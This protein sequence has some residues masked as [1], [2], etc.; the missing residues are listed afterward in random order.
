MSIVLP[1]PNCGPRP[2][3]EFEYGEIPVVPES[4]TAADER[5]LDRAFMRSNPEGPQT[6]RWFHTFGCRRWLTLR[7]DT[8]TDEVLDAAG[9]AADRQ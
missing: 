4:I 5:D 2:I 1:C 6:E 7:R 8:R 3:E 9:P